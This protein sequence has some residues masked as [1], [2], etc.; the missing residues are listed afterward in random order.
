MQLLFFLVYYKYSRFFT[1][2]QVIRGSMKFANMTECTKILAKFVE[3]ASRDWELVP[4]FRPVT[5]IF[6]LKKVDSQQP[7]DA[8]IV[9][10]KS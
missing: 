6:P 9:T 5:P 3:I 2:C 8:Y 1:F 4:G 10:Q 7:N